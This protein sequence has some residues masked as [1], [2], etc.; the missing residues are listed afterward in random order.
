MSNGFFSHGRA[1]SSPGK[2]HGNPLGVA[3]PRWRMAT[4][5]IYG[6]NVSEFE[7]NAWGTLQRNC[8]PRRWGWGIPGRRHAG[9]G[10]AGEFAC[11]RVCW[12]PRGSRYRA[13]LAGC[14]TLAEP[15]LGERGVGVAGGTQAARL[16]R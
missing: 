1:G 14:V 7:V 8:K 2:R 10:V 5:W 16:A 11:R 3:P 9:S 4:A 13:C 15:T 12:G 6:R